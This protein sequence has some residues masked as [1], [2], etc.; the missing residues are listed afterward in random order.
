MKLLALKQLRFFGAEILRF[1]CD[2]SNSNYHWCDSNRRDD[3]A[4]L[5]DRIVARLIMDDDSCADDPN[6]TKQ[7]YEK[8]TKK[9][10]LPVLE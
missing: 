8:P 10:G 7:T 5:A 4:S 9:T 1:M 6:D 2:A 3:Q